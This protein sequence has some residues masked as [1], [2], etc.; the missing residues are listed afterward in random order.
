MLN[1]TIIAKLFIAALNYIL[2]APCFA[3]PGDSQQPIN[4][5]SDKASHITLD[6]GEKTEYF[7]NVV[8]TQGSMKINGDHIVIHSQ[9]RQVKSI[10]AKGTPAHFEQQS[11]P[12]KAAV[13]AEANTLDYE[14]KSDTVILT[15]NAIIEQ[16]GTTVS[17]D[18][19]EYNIGSEQVVASGNKENESRVKMVLIPSDSQL[20]G[21]DNSTPESGTDTSNE[22]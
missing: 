8:I 18:K 9:E 17:G 22:E 14:L 4:I 13:K 15:E 2:V 12:D 21:E 20:K 3:L 11:D 10:V 19:I 6:T 16:N 1:N 5:Q 7:G